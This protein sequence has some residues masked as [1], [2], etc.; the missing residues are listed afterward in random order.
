MSASSVSFSGVLSQQ[1]TY[2]QL[3]TN[4]QDSLSKKNAFYSRPDYLKDTRRDFSQHH[5]LP[6]TYRWDTESKIIRVKK[7]L[8][9]IIIFPIAIYNLL[10]ILVGKVF[11]LPAS[12][13]SL[14]MGYPKNHANDS[15][16]RISLEDDW[17]YKRITVE[18]DGYKIDT[19]IFGKAST[20]NNG[21]WV[22]SSNGNGEFYEDALSYN[23][24]FK[25]IL[26][27]IKGNGIVFNYPGVGSSSGL[28]NRQAMAKAYRAILSFLEDQKNGIGAREII[29]YGHSIGGGVQGEA[30]NTHPLKEN[31]KYVFV[32]SRTF[33]DLSVTASILTC[34]PL[35]FLVKLLGWNIDSVESSKKLQAPEIILQTARVQEHEALSVSDLIINDGIIPA[36]A[37][38]ATTLLDD[39]NCP[40]ENKLFIGIQERHNEQLTNPSF[41]VNKIKEFL[42]S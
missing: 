11:L 27:E 20:L 36:K 19:I 5:P 8:F 14:I 32:K 25:Q 42:K 17:K 35:G 34:K 41:L 12:S 26:S 24:N 3:N 21:R 29:G 22:L 33:S 16:L 23:H 10:H 18:V 6:T 2:P 37:S 9:S 39:N 13:P 4:I 30:L 31:I 7:Q 38:L 15:R 28:P 1:N 40:K